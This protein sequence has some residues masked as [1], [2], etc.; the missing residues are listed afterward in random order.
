MTQE[1]LSTPS[2]RRATRQL[3]AFVVAG[4][5]ISIHALREEGDRNHARNPEYP[6]RIS[7]HAL[8][9]EGDRK[10]LTPYRWPESISIHALRE[11]GDAAAGNATT[12]DSVFLS[13]PSV[14]RAT[15]ATVRLG[16]TS[17][18]ISIHALRE[19]GDVGKSGEP[20]KTRNFY[21]RPP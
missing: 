20:I 10:R 21:P 9:E 14:R 1:F 3:G 12:T 4:V 15:F 7:I 19:E 6:Y 11:E 18:S 8:R 16:Q 13:T 17:F 2:V 5:T